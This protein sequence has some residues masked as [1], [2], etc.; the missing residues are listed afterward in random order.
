MCEAHGLWGVCYTECLALRQLHHLSQNVPALKP[1][2]PLAAEIDYT[3][4]AAYLPVREDAIL[5]L[6][7]RTLMLGSTCWMGACTLPVSL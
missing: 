1:N 2:Q 7:A 4:D 3:A 6:A 5:L